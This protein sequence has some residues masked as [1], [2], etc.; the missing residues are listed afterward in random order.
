MADDAVREA[1][2]RWRATGAFEDEQAYLRAK[3]QAGLSKYV[4]LDPG[5]TFGRW[6]GL[7]VRRP[8]GVVYGTQ[9]AGVCI[10]E[11]FVEGF[12]VPLGGPSFDLDQTDF[13]LPDR[14]DLTRAF[15]DDGGGCIS[16][17]STGDTLP[18]EMLER[19]ARA[20]ASIVCWE[21]TLEDRDHRGHVTLDRA[22]LAEA[23]EAWLPV[24][25]PLGPGV[26]VYENCD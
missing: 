10:H 20:V 15:H 2:R 11:R 7:V 5:G 1:E 6:L 13:L 25:S 8:T 19:L 3:V 12:Y 23:V 26:L 4:F 17:P 14:S 22:R 18:S 24:E 16:S 21:T 9:C